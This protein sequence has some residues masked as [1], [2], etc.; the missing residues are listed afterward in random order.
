LSL[1]RL[2]AYTIRETLESLRDPILLGYG[3]FGT[4]LLMIVF[5]FGISTDVNNLFFA[6]LDRNQTPESRACLEELRGSAYFLEKPLLADYA[7]L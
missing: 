4:A 7:D 2:L 3:L 1:Q 5:D 6:V